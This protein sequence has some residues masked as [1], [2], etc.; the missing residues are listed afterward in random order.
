MPEKEKGITKDLAYTV[1]YI[2]PIVGCLIAVFGYLNKR[3]QDKQ[4]SVDRQIDQVRQEVKD[5]RG[6][7]E[8]KYTFMD[9]RVTYVEI[10]TQLIDQGL[11]GVEIQMPG[12]RR[13]RR[14]FDSM[15]VF[16]P[17]PA[18]RDTNGR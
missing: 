1:K 3:S 11:A 10:K 6:E 7:S 17:V 8:K 9:R 18:P 15:A 13:M 4:A 2:V 5:M 12:V 16:A 14:A